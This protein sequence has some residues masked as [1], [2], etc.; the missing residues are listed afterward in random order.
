MKPAEEDIVEGVRIL[1]YK[2]KMPPFLASPDQL[3]RCPGAGSTSQTALVMELQIKIKSL[4]KW[5]VVFM[6]SNKKTSELNKT[7]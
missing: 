5:M 3:R 1:L 7:M 4:E 2:K 6:D